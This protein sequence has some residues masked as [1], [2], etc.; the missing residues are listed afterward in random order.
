[1]KI[2]PTDLPGVVLFEPRVFDDDRG[3]FFESWNAARYQEAGLP[4]RFVQDNLSR[5]K[6]GVLRGLHFQNPQS[7]GKLVSVLEGA[8]FDV[9]VDV[10]R[11]SPNFGSWFG[12]ELSEQNRRQLYIPPGFA[13]GFCVTSDTALF[14]YK[15]TDYYNPATECC[16]R[17]D[18]PEID[19]KWP[20]DNPQVS[21]KDH[22]GKL[23][24]EIPRSSD[25]QCIVSEADAPAEQLPDDPAICTP[26]NR[27]NER[28]ILLIGGNGQI[29]SALRGLLDQFGEVV[30]TARGAAPASKLRSLDL[31]DQDAIR[32]AVRQIEAASY[33]Q[34]R[35]LHSS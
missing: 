33:R 3:Y 12:I 9:A 10:R 6:R 16:L 7:Q 5:S 34:C 29:G 14:A 24:C 28:R 17:W 20:I 4:E 18:D 35:C 30:A 2:I 31:T 11:G 1:M 21:E 15:C 22:Q 13:H 27:S 25:C 23:L 26:R 19:I 32:A 8:V